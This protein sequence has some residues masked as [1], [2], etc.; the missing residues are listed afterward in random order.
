MR[1][2]WQCFIECYCFCVESIAKERS[3]PIHFQIFD[4][5]Y[6]LKYLK[7][8]SGLQNE[9]KVL[10][11]CERKMRNL[12]LFNQLQ[13]LKNYLSFSISRMY[14]PCYHVKEHFFHFEN[15]W[16]LKFWI[17]KSRVQTQSKDKRNASSNVDSIF[18]YYYSEKMGFRFYISY[19]K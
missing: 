19:F 17:F 13:A 5:T 3:E 15:D 6:G 1:E 16:N 9:E 12:L 4:T 18:V 7:W 2:P 10:G 11:R 14:L 8:F